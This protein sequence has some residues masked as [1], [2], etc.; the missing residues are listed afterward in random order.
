MKK[1][2]IAVYSASSD[3]IDKAYFEAAE[4]LGRL[5][6]G[7][8]AT[9][10]NGGGK[11]GLMAAST[12]GALAAGGNVIGV[13]PQFMVEAG[14]AH[15]GLTETIV[16]STMHERKATMARL[17]R[18]VIALPGGVGTLEEV[19][20]M[21]TWRKLHLF[22]GPVVIL[23]INGY[24]DGLLLWLNRSVEEKFTDYPLPWLVADT[25][26]Q[27]IDLIFANAAN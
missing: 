19:A 6:A 16:T 11:M 23:N 10:V 14:R 7:R 20:E 25:P 1:N 2:G 3:N 26:E 24:Y 15:Q 21:M 22:D 13:I 12:N 27:A 18:A 9:L 17:S 5:I 8:G 4:R